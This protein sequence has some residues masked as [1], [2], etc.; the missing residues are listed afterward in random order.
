MVI[1]YIVQVMDGGNLIWDIAA[2]KV[3]R[4]VQ[5]LKVLM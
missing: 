5:E 2:I 4:L 3:D 1:A